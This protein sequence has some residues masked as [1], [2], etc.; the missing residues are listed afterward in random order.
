MVRRPRPSKNLKIEVIPETPKINRPQQLFEE[1]K[2][3]SPL[4]EFLVVYGWAILV[5]LAAIGA[6]L[7]FGVISPWN[8]MPKK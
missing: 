4:M 7:Y 5:I 3:L 2:P 8:L 1:E 6:L